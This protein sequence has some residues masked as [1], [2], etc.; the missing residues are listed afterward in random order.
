MKRRVF[1]KSKKLMVILCGIPSRRN[2]KEEESRARSF[3]DGLFESAALL[4]DEDDDY[5]ANDQNTLAHIIMKLSVCSLLDVSNNAKPFCSME[6]EALKPRTF[7]DLLDQHKALLFSSEDKDKPLTPDDFGQFVVD[8]KL[9]YYPYVG[10]AAPRSIIPVSAGKDI[11]FT[12]NERYEQNICKREKHLHRRFLRVIQQEKKSAIA[13]FFVLSLTPTSPFF[14]HDSPPDQPIPF[15]HELAQTPNPPEYIFFYCETAPLDGGET[16]LMDS[17]LVYRF[18]QEH[19]AEFLSKLREHGAR[20]I[21][22][23]PA[24][25]DPTSPIGRSYKNT[26]HV[27]NPQELEKKLSQVEGCSWEWKENGSVRVT[28]EAVPGE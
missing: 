17:T 22:T 2:R 1:W 16:P 13:W 7:I 3:L 26:W 19:H 21:R 15:H 24:D 14:V 9:T 6:W 18:V 10:G 4:I 23:L 11:V 28:T 8:R 25:D 5:K 20:Y 12:A 27:S